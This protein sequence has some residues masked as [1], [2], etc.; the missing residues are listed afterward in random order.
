MKRT[1]LVSLFA[2]LLAQ[3][4]EIEGVRTFDNCS[5]P[6]DQV[7]EYRRNVA[8]EEGKAR[9]HIITRPDAGGCYYFK[10]TGPGVDGNHAWLERDVISTEHGRQEIWLVL[11]GTSASGYAVVKRELRSSR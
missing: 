7:E 10:V 3:A 4:A 8:K 5:G 6:G 2:A 9:F 11:D 1:M